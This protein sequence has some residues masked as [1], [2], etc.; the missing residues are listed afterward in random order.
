MARATVLGEQRE[1]LLRIGGNRV[2]LPRSERVERC[3]DEHQGALECGKRPGD[4]LE[5]WLPVVC[6]FEQRDVLGHFADPRDHGLAVGHAHF[7]GV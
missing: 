1:A 3:V 7:G 5:R 4:V 6:E 2:L